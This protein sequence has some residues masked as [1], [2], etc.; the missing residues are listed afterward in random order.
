M[1]LQDLKRGLGNWTL[2]L[3]IVVYTAILVMMMGPYTLGAIGSSPVL[4]FG[5]LLAGELAFLPSLLCVLPLSTAF[6][7]EWTSLYYRFAVSRLGWKRYGIERVVSTAILGGFSIML[8]LTFCMLACYLNFPEANATEH[9]FKMDFPLY[10]S[11]LPGGPAQMNTLSQGQILRLERWLA[12]V[13]LLRLFTFGACWSQL[14]LAVSAWV[15]DWALVQVIPF[16]VFALTDW[17][18]SNA[19]LHFLD[20]SSLIGLGGLAFYPLWVSFVVPLCW[21]IIFVTLFI[22][23]LRR[24][25]ARE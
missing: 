1:V 6:Y 12:L 8:P 3:G 22:L 24:R 2:W 14:G 7:D 11:W 19:G 25:R 10:R 5:W 23:G 9:V 18:A 20:C 21:G 4:I 17:I 13:W 15:D 16:V